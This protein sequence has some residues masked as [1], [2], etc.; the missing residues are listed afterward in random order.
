MATTYSPRSNQAPSVPVDRLVE[1]AC[2]APSVHNTQ[3]WQWRYDGEV[4]TLLAD[5]ERQL[6]ASDPSGRNLTISCGAALHHLQFAAHA[7]GC[8]ADVTLV[9][10]GDDHRELARVVLRPGLEC[11]VDDD[12]IELIRARCTDRRRFTEW[13]VPADR[14]DRLC[15]MVASWGAQATTV[16]QEG[17][18]I[19][20]EVLANQALTFSEMEATLRHEQDTWLDRSPVDGIP[21]D[22]LT[23]DADPLHSRSR[24]RSSGL[25]DTRLVIH[26]GDRVIAI[27]SADDDRL[28]WLRTGQALS[29]VWLEATRMGVSVVPMSQPMEVDDVRREIGRT[30]L[31]G[32]FQPHILIQ[33]GLQAIGRTGLSR[34]PRRRLEEVLEVDRKGLVP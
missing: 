8:D 28:S 30:V 25:E 11:P 21:R 31:H 15:R 12:A 7:L 18:R 33:V 24:F 19:R 10:D 29:A 5:E 9:P 23:Q 14:L 1:L 22:H 4:L 26:G 16:L 13:P 27:G 6:T 17:D 20:L 3:P 32:A 2:M 34:T